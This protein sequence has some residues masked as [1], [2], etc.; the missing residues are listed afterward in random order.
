MDSELLWLPCCIGYSFPD[1]GLLTPGV[2][3]G[4][5]RLAL[6]LYGDHE[7][8]QTPFMGSSLSNMDLSKVALHVGAVSHPVSLLPTRVKGCCVDLLSFGACVDS[9]CHDCMSLLLGRW[10]R[11][12]HGIWRGA[13]CRMCVMEVLF[14][15]PVG[16]MGIQDFLGSLQGRPFALGCWLITPPQ[17]SQ[18]LS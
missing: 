14:I 9:L 12:A 17:V 1:K 15:L 10:V 11:G 13:P 4:Q 3:K 7:P 6:H 16:W 18:E 2:N 8:S 5:G